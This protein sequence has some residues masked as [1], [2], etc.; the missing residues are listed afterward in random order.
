[1]GNET[2][3]TGKVSTF[4]PFPVFYASDTDCTQLIELFLTALDRNGTA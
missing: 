3:F 2:R 4:A 1:M